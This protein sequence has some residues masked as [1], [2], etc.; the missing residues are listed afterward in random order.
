MFLSQGQVN[1]NTMQIRAV[2]STKNISGLKVVTRM[3]GGI[4]PPCGAC[5]PTISENSTIPSLRKGRISVT[6]DIKTESW[7]QVYRPWSSETEQLD[8]TCR[9]VSMFPQNGHLS[10]VR[11]PQRFRLSR[12]GRVFI[13]ALMAN[14]RTPCGISHRKLLQVIQSL[15]SMI[16]AK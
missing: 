11:L 1:S 4:V 8:N 2:S 15:S 5:K 9:S 14:L 13:P 6:I 7:R 3:W 10:F 12:V 16:N